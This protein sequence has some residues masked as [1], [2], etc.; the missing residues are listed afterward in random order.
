MDPQFF[1]V[2]D[3][4]RQL[5]FEGIHLANASSFSPN[6]PRWFVVDIYKTVGGRYIVAGSGKSLVVHRP[7]CDQM[8]EKNAKSKPALKNSVPC[9]T[10]RPILTEDV[11]HEVNR[12]WAQVS[13]DPNAIIER[14]RLRDAD[15][16]WYIPKTSTTAL[17]K[18][19]EQDNGIKEAFYAPQRIK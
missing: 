18:A 4:G 17:L 9:P 7:N 10:C 11:C 12:E 16:V 19:A 15:G 13:E 5:D 2:F 1:T 6:K 14:L 3:R 8:K